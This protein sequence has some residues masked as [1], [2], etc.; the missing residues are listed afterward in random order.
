MARD[1]ETR[2]RCCLLSPG[3]TEL[4]V[5]PAA[6]IVICRVRPDAELPLS[7]LTPDGGDIGAM[8]PTS[9][10]HWLLFNPLEHDGL[11]PFDLLVMTSGNK[12]SEPICIGN[13]EAFSRLA[14]IADCFL[15]HD[16]EI[17]LRADDSL[18]VVHAGERSQVWRF[19]RGDAP[20]PL[21]ISRAVPAP[22]LGMGAEIKNSVAVGLDDSIYLSPHVGDLE[23]PQ[24]QE[25]LERMAREF[26]AFLHAR[27]QMIAV[28]KHPDM[29]SSRLGRLIGAREKITVVEI[30]H[31]A[32]HAAAC[33]AESSLEE[34]LAL[35]FDGTGLGDDGTIWGAELLHCRPGGWTRLSSFR[36][37]RLPGGD[38][39]VR[40][41]R[42]QLFGRW[43]DADLLPAPE[44]LQACGM[45]E[46]EAAIWAQQCRRGLNA[47]LSH[48]AGRLFDACA[49]LLGF[50]G[51]EV[52]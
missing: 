33:M 49:A 36:P 38:A 6:P 11:P 29:F 17:N 2:Q 26:P 34:C 45:N 32:A 14:G 47:P 35:V 37:V 1:L 22:V 9:P 40:E 52:T 4:L 8:L 25:G 43:F 10:L 19:A 7:A 3:E 20:L 13:E 28:D 21:K 15:C 51:H 41:P 46:Q 39:A 50:I 23:T 16:R 44:L 12:R 18:T 24:A 48:A 30:Q 27:P 5:S 31:H 42:R